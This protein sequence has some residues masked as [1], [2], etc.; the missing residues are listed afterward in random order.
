MHSH[1]Q[2]SWTYRP[3]GSSHYFFINFVEN[4]GLNFKNP[5]FKTDICSAT[6]CWAVFRFQKRN[7]KLAS[8]LFLDP[9]IMISELE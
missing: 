1:K 6:W 8:F 5:I 3:S 2:G 7:P 9:V 4:D